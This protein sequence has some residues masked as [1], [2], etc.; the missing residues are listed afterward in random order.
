VK[1][2]VAADVLPDGTHIPAGA[3]LIYSP[4]VVNRLKVF[5]GPDADMFR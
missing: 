4:F 1:F 3:Q 2:A 5:W